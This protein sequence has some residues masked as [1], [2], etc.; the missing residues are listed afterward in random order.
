MRQQSVLKHFSTKLSR[1]RNKALKDILSKRGIVL[2][3]AM[4]ETRQQNRAA[5]REN[6]NVIEAARAM[7]NQKGLS[8]KIWME[9]CNTAV[10]ILNHTAPTPVNGKSPVELWFGQTSNFDINRL[11]V[12]ETT[13]W[14]LLPKR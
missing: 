12:F 7:I 11:R 10:F 5:E 8:V 9:A 1:G 2:R 6:R 14:C 13:V 3:V 4:T